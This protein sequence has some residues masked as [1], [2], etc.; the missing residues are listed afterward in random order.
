MTIHF[1]SYASNLKANEFSEQINNLTSLQRNFIDM[2]LRNSNRELF[3]RRYTLDEKLLCLSIYKRSAA[4]YRYLC[5]ILPF[6]SPSSLKLILKRIKLDTGMTQTMKALLKDASERMKDD[7]EK[8]CVL[9]WD[10]ISL[11]LHVDY[12]A[13]KD[14]VIGFEDWGTNRSNKYADHALVFMLRGIKTGWKIPLTYNFCASQTTYGQLSACIKEVVRDV[15]N[16][17][18]NIV[19]TVC[20]QG[21]SNMKAIKLLQSETDKVRE[22]KSLTPCKY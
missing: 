2:I 9:M 6:P 3:G 13:E 16:S 15:T 14:K 21:S 18:F 20:D 11:K 4:T 22:E 17:G 5:S 1:F 12:S 7:Q 8:V 10:E 19:A